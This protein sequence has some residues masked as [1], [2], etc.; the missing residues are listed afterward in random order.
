MDDSP[1]ASGVITFTGPNGQ[2]GTGK[3]EQG[4]YEVRTVAGANRVQVSA[5]VVVATRPESKSPGAALV[6]ITEESLPDKYHV[7]SELTFDAQSGGNT[8]DWALQGKP[9]KK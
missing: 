7:R 8:K 3:V 6:E 1:L 4:R 2:S 5:P 9:K